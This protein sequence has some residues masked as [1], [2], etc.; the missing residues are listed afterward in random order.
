MICYCYNIL[1]IIAVTELDTGFPWLR[2]QT[3]NLRFLSLKS[4]KRLERVKDS[5]QKVAETNRVSKCD[6]AMKGKKRMS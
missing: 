2:K 3:S 5:K 4:A 1:H 6:N